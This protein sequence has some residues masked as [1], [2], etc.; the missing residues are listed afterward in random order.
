MQ[1]P[2]FLLPAHNGG[3]I[4]LSNYRGSNPVVLFFVREYNCMQ[5]RAMV[6]QL[7][8][9]YGDFLA[10]GAEVFVIIG[11]SIERAQRYAQLM[12]TPFRVLVDPQREVYHRYGL[13]KAVFVVQRTAAVVIDKQGVLCYFK[14]TANATTWLQEAPQLLE[15]LRSLYAPQ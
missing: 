5:C 7:G 9:R 1:A 3:E 14:T 10:A 12:Q 2:D 11:E 4:R 13:H 15:T 6:T 8:Q